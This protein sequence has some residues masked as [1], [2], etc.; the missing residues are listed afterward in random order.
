MT[1]ISELLS[2]ENIFFC[3]HNLYFGFP[4]IAVWRC[5]RKLNYFVVSALE[6]KTLKHIW[7]RRFLLRTKI[8][9]SFSLDF[10][11]GNCVFKVSDFHGRVSLHLMKY[12][13][14]IK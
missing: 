12:S 10:V 2:N 13:N 8:K 4:N 1:K 5:K 9:F 14:L 3:R 6:A 11:A 7:Q